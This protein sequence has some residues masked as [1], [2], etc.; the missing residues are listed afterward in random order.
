VI[1]EKKARSRQRGALATCPE[2]GGETGQVRRAEGNWRAIAGDSSP[3]GESRNH[4]L[5]ASAA[6]GNRLSVLPV[7]GAEQQRAPGQDDPTDVIGDCFN[8]ICEAALT[9]QGENARGRLDCGVK[10]GKIFEHHRTPH[11]VVRDGGQP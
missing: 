2:E 3:P 7:R 5:K 10:L 11:T 1:L 8:A 6:L 4:L 9:S